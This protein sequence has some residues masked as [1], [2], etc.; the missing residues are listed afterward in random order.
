M[1]ARTDLKATPR[2]VTVTIDDLLTRCDILVK[3]I[4]VFK[5]F[6]AGTRQGNNPEH[7]STSN[8]E[9][10][11]DIRQFHAPVLAELK[12]LQKVCVLDI[13]TYSFID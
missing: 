5:T 3:E 2:G 1:A 10:A 6:V 12:S 8:I 4:D 11:V 9:H 7:A 13:H